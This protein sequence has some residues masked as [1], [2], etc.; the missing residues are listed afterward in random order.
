MS[1]P[2]QLV[3]DWPEMLNEL[4]RL[5]IRTG[6]I[7]EFTGLSTGNIRE[8][9]LGLKSPMHANGER[10]IAFWIQATRK[11]RAQLPMIERVG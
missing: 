10:I 3:V 8:Y 7:G 11:E 6:M 9:R 4:R 2:I 5:Q 1:V